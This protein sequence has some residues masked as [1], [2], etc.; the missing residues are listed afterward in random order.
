MDVEL[1][2]PTGSPDGDLDPSSEVARL[3]RRAQGKDAEAF[4]ELI[5]RYERMALSIAYSVLGDATAAGDV[6]QEAFVRAWERLGDLKD[7]ARF[8]P[9]LGGVVRN[10]AIDA[11]RRS[12]LQPR[13]LPDN[14]G[15]ARPVVAGAA[16]DGRRAPNPLDELTRR[17][18]RELLNS[19]LADL[20]EVSRSAVVLRYF[21]GLSSK[22]IG[23]LLNLAPAAVDMRLSR[24]RQQLRR[25]LQATG[26]FAGEQE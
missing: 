26:V 15:Q 22:E 13:S 16:D 5:G 1:K 4:T 21:D 17:E 23:E 25:T 8:G 10:G 6:A 24:A 12:R 14:P 7:P 20:D 3:V 9:W 11:R 18:R 19:A 2:Q